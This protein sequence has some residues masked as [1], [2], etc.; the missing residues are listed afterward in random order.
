MMH[1]LNLSTGL[2]HRTGPVNCCTRLNH[3][4]GPLNW[5]TVQIKQLTVLHGG[6]PVLDPGDVAAQFVLALAVL[7]ELG[8][9]TEAPHVVQ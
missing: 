6:A 8:L 9:D 3:W 5:C 4:T 2:A 1:I 7:D